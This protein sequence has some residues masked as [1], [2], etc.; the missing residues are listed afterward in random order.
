M[1]MPQCPCYNCITVP[2]CRHKT[3]GDII[4]CPLIEKYTSSYNLQTYFLC[5]I[6]IHKSLKPTRWAVDYDDGRFIEYEC[7]DG[8]W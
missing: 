8:E 1:N 4:I 6:A 3:F 7:D 5:R 2:V